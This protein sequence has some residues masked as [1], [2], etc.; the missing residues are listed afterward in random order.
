MLAGISGM[1]WKM[2]NPHFSLSLSLPLSLSLRFSSN[3]QRN[4]KEKRKRQ[5]YMSVMSIFAPLV[6]LWTSRKGTL[7]PS[8]QTSHRFWCTAGAQQQIKRELNAQSAQM[9]W[10]LDKAGAYAA[11]ILDEGG[12]QWWCFPK[13]MRRWRNCSQAGGLKEMVC[14]SGHKCKA[15]HAQDLITTF[16]ETSAFFL[17]SKFPSRAFLQAGNST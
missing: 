9:G 17:S 15:L 14:S 10:Y 5:C 12:W 6:S 13:M 8:P 2:E 3:K 16:N 11:D 7:S 4:L 1:N